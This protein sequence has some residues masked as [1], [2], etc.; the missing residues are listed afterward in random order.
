MNPF[1]AS[2]IFTVHCKDETSLLTFILWTDP[3]QGPSGNWWA[4]YDIVTDG[5]G[6]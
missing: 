1:K 6:G 5:M 3:F 4:T 2:D